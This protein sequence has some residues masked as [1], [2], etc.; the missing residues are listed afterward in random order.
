M[1]MDWQ[2]LIVGVL[3]LSALVYLG[4]MTMRAWRGRGVGC[5]GCKCSGTARSS[6]SGGTVDT[7]IPVEQITLRRR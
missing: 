4:W 1:K 7:L 2:L 3:V 6:N 5:G